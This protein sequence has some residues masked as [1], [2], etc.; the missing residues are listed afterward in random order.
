MSTIYAQVEQHGKPQPCQISEPI[1][2][3][4][5]GVITIQRGDFPAVFLS[6][7]RHRLADEL[8]RVVNTLKGKFQ[9]A[10]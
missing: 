5:N 1:I 3:G 9:D 6:G 7:N 4:N 2:H 8:A 10:E